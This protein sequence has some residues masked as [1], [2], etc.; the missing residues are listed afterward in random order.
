MFASFE[1]EAPQVLKFDKLKKDTKKQKE[2]PKEV[3][4]AGLSIVP[5]KTNKAQIEQRET[6]K[7]GIIPHHPSSTIFNGASGSGKSNLLVN[8]LTRPEFYGKRNGKHYFDKIHM[9]SPT[10]GEMDDL[11]QHLIDHCGLET[12]DIHNEFDQKLL[13]SIL[14]DQQKAIKKKGIHKSPKTLLLLD[15]IQSDKK[16][17]ASKAIKR[18]FLMNRHYNTSTWLC[19]QSFNLTPRA[20]RLQANN[21]FL[22]PMGGS[23]KKVLIDEFSPPGLTKK[24]FE[25]L[26]DHATSEQY[27][28]LHV[29]KKQPPATRFR[30]N[31]DTI[32]EYRK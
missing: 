25:E 3:K 18:L 22:F 4:K 9:F 27:Q 19:G 7:Q 5:F 10:A 29:A 31:L 26:V 12:S 23:E 8:L 1:D 24:E 20:C 28:F 32:L 17:L 13:L 6:M 30:K 16:F 14:D 21:L 15:D 2:L 11:C